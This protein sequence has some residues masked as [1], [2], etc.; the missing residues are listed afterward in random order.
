MWSPASFSGLRPGTRL[1]HRRLSYNGLPRKSR[2]G[3]LL[4]GSFCSTQTGSPRITRC[5]M[6]PIGLRHHSTAPPLRPAVEE[7][8]HDGSWYT[9]FRQVSETLFWHVD[10]IKSPC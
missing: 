5:K 9:G 3:M 10:H 2:P 4:K 7:A 8:E 1:R 6:P